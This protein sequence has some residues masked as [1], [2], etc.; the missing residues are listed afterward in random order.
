[1]DDRFVSSDASA[2]IHGVEL[3]KADYEE[4]LQNTVW[5]SWIGIKAL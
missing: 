2:H 5:V 1:M 3:G 4:L